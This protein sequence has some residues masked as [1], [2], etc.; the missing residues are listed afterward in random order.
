MCKGVSVGQGHSAEF[1]LGVQVETG[2]P[3]VVLG[4]GGICSRNWHKIT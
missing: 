4:V 2:V 1:G 3:G